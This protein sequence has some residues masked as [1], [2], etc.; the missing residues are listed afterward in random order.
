MEKVTGIQVRIDNLEIALNQAKRN[1]NIEESERLTESYLKLCKKANVSPNI[2]R[3]DFKV[4]AAMRKDI[5]KQLKAN[6]IEVLK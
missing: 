6:G 5:Q 1:G 3:K 2:I 4:T